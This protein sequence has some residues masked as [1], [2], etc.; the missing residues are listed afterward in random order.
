[1]TR[2]DHNRA[3]AQVAARAGAPVASV[4]N[5][6]IWGNHSATQYPDIFHAKVGGRPALEAVGGLDWVEKELIPTVQQRGAAIIE[7]RGASSAASAANA[8]IGLHEGLGAGHE[9]RR[10]DVDGRALQRH[11]RDARR[12]L[13]QLSRLRLPPANTGSSRISRSTISR[14]N[15]STGARRSWSMNVTASPAWDCCL[16]PVRIH[17]KHGADRVALVADGRRRGLGMGG[18]ERLDGAQCVKT[19]GLTNPSR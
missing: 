2:L 15:G 17:M 7:A 4:T 8:A 12:R 1:M 6:S 3:V 14:A 19:G 5:L 16:E 11:L 9:A 13:L 18:N 10:L